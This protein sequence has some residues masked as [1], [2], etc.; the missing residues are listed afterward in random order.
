[1]SDT[2]KSWAFWI[3]L[4]LLLKLVSILTSGQVGF[5]DRIKRTFTIRVTLTSGRVG[6]FLYIV[7]LE[8][9]YRV[10]QFRNKPIY[11]ICQLIKANQYSSY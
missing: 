4:S 5:L 2:I 6:F 10:S 8:P 3:E 9:Q 7:F 1:M 11:F